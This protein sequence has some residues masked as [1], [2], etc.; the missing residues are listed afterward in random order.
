MDSTTQSLK[1]ADLKN[2]IASL[3]TAVGELTTT[4]KKL[5]SGNG[6]AA[7]LLNDADMYKELKNTIT[8]LNTLVDDVRIHPKRYINVSVFG[9]KDKTTPLHKPIADT[10][11]HE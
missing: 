7:K 5:N 2:T 9:K 11:A 6:T 8:S 4:L 1:Q 3:Q 10:V